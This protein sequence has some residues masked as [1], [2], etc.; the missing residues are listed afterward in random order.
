MLHDP[1]NDVQVKWNE[2][3][4]Y[5]LTIPVLR[6]SFVTLA[7]FEFSV[8][9]LVD[10]EKLTKNL[11]GENAVG[12]LGC[13]VREQATK[14][15]VAGVTADHATDRPV[16]KVWV[17]SHAIFPTTGSLVGQQIHGDDTILISAVVEV[18]EERHVHRPRI[19]CDVKVVARER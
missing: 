7:I 8:R 6:D 13:V 9:I 11:L 4:L 14:K 3:V 15:E 1:R 10:C 12:L 17:V 5:W 2:A 18:T 16:V 19:A